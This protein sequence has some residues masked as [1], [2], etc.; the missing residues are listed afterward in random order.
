MSIYSAA[1]VVRELAYGGKFKQIGIGILWFAA[2][3]CQI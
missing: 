3:F 1:E 2:L